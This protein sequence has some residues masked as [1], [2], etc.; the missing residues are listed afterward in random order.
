MWRYIAG[1]VVHNILNE[2]SVFTFKGE[3]VQEE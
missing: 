1:P 2:P 3:E